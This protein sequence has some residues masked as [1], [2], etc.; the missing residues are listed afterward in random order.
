MEQQNYSQKKDPICLKALF[1]YIN[2]NYVS[3]LSNHGSRHRI[4]I[5]AKGL[6]IA[7][8]VLAEGLDPFEK[9][10]IKASNR[11]KKRIHIR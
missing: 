11:K 9:K 4:S 5:T 3:N 6:K 10:L 7:E 1:E 8:A 2:K